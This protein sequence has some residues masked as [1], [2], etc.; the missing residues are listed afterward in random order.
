MTEECNKKNQF[1][2]DDFQVYRSNHHKYLTLLTKKWGMSIYLE[3]SGIIFLAL[4]I[5]YYILFAQPSKAPQESTKE[6]IDTFSFHWNVVVIIII[7]SG[8]LVFLGLVSLFFRLIATS[9]SIEKKETTPL[10]KIAN[11]QKHYL[12]FILKCFLFILPF[13]LPF[14]FYS[15]YKPINENITVHH[16][17]CG[18]P[19]LFS[20]A[21]YLI[22]FNSNQFNAI[23]W[24]IIL[25][26]ST[27]LWSNL[28]TQIKGKTSR[29]STTFIGVFILLFLCLR[30]FALSSWM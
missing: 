19:G 10:V 25:F 6:L 22:D 13:L 17:G 11:S 23:L 20:D 1:P 29:D 16:F 14:T 30:F 3:F 7:A 21:G 12:R 24:G 8:I 27:F 18:C 15:F 26:V 5:T 4:G 9:I 2:K 28:T